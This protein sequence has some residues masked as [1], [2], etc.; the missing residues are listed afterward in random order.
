[1][2]PL[3]SI[4]IPAYNV[5]KHISRAIE[6]CINQTLKDIEILIIDDCGSDR[7]IEIARQYAMNDNRIK[8]ISN[9]KNL[10]T[11]LSR[12]DGALHASADYIMFLDADDFLSLEAC[13]ICYKEIEDGIDFIAFNMMVELGGGGWNCFLL[14][15]ESREFSIAEFEAYV[16]YQNATYWHIVTKL[17]RKATFL[18]A[19]NELKIEHHLISSED[20]LQTFMLLIYTKRCK[21]IKN[22]LYYYCH[23][24]TSITK[25]SDNSK[26]QNAID[27][28]NFVIDKINSLSK[29]L[30]IYHIRFAEIMRYDLTC[31]KLNIIRSINK[32]LAYYL[33]SS[34]KKKY[35]YKLRKILAR[36]FVNSFRAKS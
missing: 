26:I 16:I 11:F 35:I 33:A 4:I 1:M 25:T 19:I 29:N 18:Q 3:I 9:K 7:S 2:K 12:N 30:A 5:E 22:S 13:E 24:Q 14:Y 20:V 15:R 21:I 6:S 36:K 32:S 8:I 23:N 17:I 34:F 27:N 31:S 28:H 10:G